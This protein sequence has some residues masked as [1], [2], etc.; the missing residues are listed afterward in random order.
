MRKTLFDIYTEVLTRTNA[1]KGIVWITFTPLLGMSEV[2]RMFLDAKERTPDRADICMTIDDVAHY[3]QEERDR[4]V[5]SYPA[6]EREARSKGI[7]VLGSGNGYLPIA[8]ERLLLNRS[9]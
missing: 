2:V 5:A 6:H 8:E 9:R 3:T 4:I 1:T 7:P